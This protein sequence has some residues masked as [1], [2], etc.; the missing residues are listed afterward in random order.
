MEWLY[1]K[2]LVTYEV[3]EK[4]MQDRVVSI[5]I[6]DRRELIWGLQHPPLFTAGTSSHESDLL[7]TFGFPVY[8]TGRGGKFTYHG[9]GQL[10]VYVMIDLNKHGLDIRQYVATLENWIIDCLKHLDIHAER[11][12]GRIGIWVQNPR[13]QDEKIAAIGV[14][15]TKG[16]TWHGMAINVS[17]NL[18]H[19]G[20]I[21]P[22]GLAEFGVISMAK[23]GGQVEI[24]DVFQVLKEISPFKIT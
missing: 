10:V 19:F 23:L 13:G 20:G 21:V 18:S 2:D 22:C 11:R 17:P 6:Q 7:D 3:A 1:S 4:V 15:V 14:R 16:I 12:E 9:P 24:Q 5:Q 8:Q